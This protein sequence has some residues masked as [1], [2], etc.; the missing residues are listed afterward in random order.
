[1]EEVK[2]VG[3]VTDWQTIR[4]LSWRWTPTGWQGARETIAGVLATDWLYGIWTYM[5]NLIMSRKGNSLF[6]PKVILI[7]LAWS[8]RVGLKLGYYDRVKPLECVTKITRFIKSMIASS[9][10]T[11][12]IICQSIAVTI[13]LGVIWI[14]MTWQSSRFEFNVTADVRG[15]ISCAHSHWPSYLDRP[16]NLC[17][18][19]TNHSGRSSV[20]KGKLPKPLSFDNG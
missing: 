17:N 5:N 9:W 13:V 4:G 6:L 15:H 8:S 11:D 3:L 10:T 7:V 18:P 1:M 19:K 16:R 2:V 12:L 14:C 20:E